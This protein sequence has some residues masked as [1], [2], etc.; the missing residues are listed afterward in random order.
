MKK[1]LPKQVKLQTLNKTTK[2]KK[3]F[4]I[5]QPKLKKKIRKKIKQYTQKPKTDQKKS[6][7]KIKALKSYIPKDPFMGINYLKINVQNLKNF[8][9]YPV[10]KYDPTLILSEQNISSLVNSKAKSKYF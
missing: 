2:T 5:S 3:D 9:S 6:L 10:E 1:Y 4:F 8:N 7:R